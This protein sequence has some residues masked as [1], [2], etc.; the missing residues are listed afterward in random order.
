MEKEFYITKEQ[1][2]ALKEA[3]KKRSYHSAKDV[4]IYNILRSKPADNGFC[5]K[6][7]NIQGNNEWYAF[8][9]ATYSAGTFCSPHRKYA[10][11]IDPKWGLVSRWI[12][13]PGKAEE[14]FKATFGIEMPE[15]I[16][17]KISESKK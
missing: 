5:P 6:T 4:I 10:K 8:N 1:F 14:E 15:D 9:T 12:D 7:K 11:V 13:D 2:I 3:W 17:T 16:K